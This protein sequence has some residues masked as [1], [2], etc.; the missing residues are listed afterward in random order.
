MPGGS[1]S[2]YDALYA[3]AC[4][5]G[6]MAENAGGV[7]FAGGADSEDNLVWAIA[8]NM[9]AT[10]LGIGGDACSPGWSDTE[11]AWQAILI[12]SAQLTGLTGTAINAGNMDAPLGGIVCNLEQVAVNTGT[13]A[14]GLAGGSYLNLLN[15]IGCATAQIA[16]N[17]FAPPDPVQEFIDALNLFGWDVLL[18]GDRGTSTVVNGQPVSSWADQSGNGNNASQTGSARPALVTN[19]VNGHPALAFD[20]V[21]DFMLGN[22]VDTTLFL[23][24][25]VVYKAISAG[26]GSRI[27]AVGPTGQDE[28]GVTT[29][30]IS[31]RLANTD[32]QLGVFRQPEGNIGVVTTAQGAFHLASSVFSDDGQGGILCTVAEDGTTNSGGSSGGAFGTDQYAI[33]SSIAANSFFSGQVAFRA[34][35]ASDK[36]VDMPAI[37]ALI[38]AF[39]ATP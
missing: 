10:I 35:S 28:A 16:T 38:Q 23:T 12:Y 21:N 13:P 8:C 32:T 11:S 31:I 30:A 37:L 22:F 29:G 7:A 3:I 39:Y 9:R 17:G 33:A 14:M 4:S 2:E 36:T 34:I 6:A 26:A 25:V 20:G 1:S 5:T 18:V 24:D 19:A 15:S 27:S